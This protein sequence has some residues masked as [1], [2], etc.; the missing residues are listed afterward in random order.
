MSLIYESKRQKLAPRH[1]YFKRVIRSFLGGGLLI[2]IWLAVGMIGYSVTIPEFDIYDSFLNASM[3]MSGM[4]PI[5]DPRIELSSA[6][7]VFASLFAIFSGIIFI[8]AFAIL[9]TP[10]AHRFFH[11]LHIDD[12]AQ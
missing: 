10:V 8:S 11:K 2:G 5:M 3:I 1:I 4:G 7:K 12:D 9:I 6:A